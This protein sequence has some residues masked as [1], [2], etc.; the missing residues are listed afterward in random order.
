MIMIQND[1]S[2][3]Y[4]MSLEEFAGWLGNK[5]VPVPLGFQL[6]YHEKR[7]TVIPGPKGT[8]K[9]QRSLENGKFMT[10][11]FRF[12]EASQDVV[13]QLVTV[14]GLVTTLERVLVGIGKFLPVAE[15]T[16]NWLVPTL[17][18]D[19]DSPTLKELGE[20]VGVS[21]STAHKYVQRLRKLR[22]LYP[23]QGGYVDRDIWLTHAG[24]AVLEALT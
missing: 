19:H 1:T 15:T 13:V 18:K 8:R 4:A 21:T 5:S 22:L 3:E 24:Y 10:L 12:S 9:V 20:V 6:D 2:G 7:W 16:L 14:D 17:M 23:R 11:E